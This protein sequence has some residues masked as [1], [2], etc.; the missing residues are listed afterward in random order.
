MTN[1]PSIEDQLRDWVNQLAPEHKQMLLG[2]LA[3]D[4]RVQRPAR[5]DFALTQLQRLCADRNLNWDSLTEGERESFLDSLIRENEMYSTHV[6]GA[7]TAM[8]SPCHHCG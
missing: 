8:I 4:D 3:E 2:M 7:A 5:L 1:E 6:G